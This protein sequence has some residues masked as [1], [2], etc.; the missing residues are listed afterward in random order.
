M[1][2]Y[3]YSNYCYDWP[4][5]S[6]TKRAEEIMLKDKRNLRVIQIAYQRLHQEQLQDIHMQIEVWFD[7]FTFNKWFDKFVSTG[8]GPRKHITR[9]IGITPENCIW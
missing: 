5:I 4:L 1:G 2:Y 7:P 3:G 6:A 9:I 8:Y